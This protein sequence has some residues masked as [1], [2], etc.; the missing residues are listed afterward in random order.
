VK[1]GRIV[2]QGK[3]IELLQKKGYYHDLYSRQFEEESSM[4]ILEA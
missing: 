3:H 4:R 1:D 2:E